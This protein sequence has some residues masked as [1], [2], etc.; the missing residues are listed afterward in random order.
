MG[1]KFDFLSVP[2]SKDGGKT[3][4]LYPKLVFDETISWKRIVE[5]VAHDTGFTPGNIVGVMHEVEARVLRYLSYGSRVQVGDMCYA[6]PTVETDRDIADESEVHAQ[7]V[8]FGKV[9]LHPAKNFRPQG[10]LV[11]ADRYSKF[12]KSSSDLSVQQRY[13]R[14]EAYLSEHGVI[15][16]TQYGELTGLLRTRAQNDL[17]RWLAEG[18]LESLGQ[19]THKVYRLSDK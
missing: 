5:E 1:A 10:P 14:L 19:A 8:R 16:R 13:E 4:I 17:N 11:R 2:N 6:E 3:R 18:K 12:R 7:S 9:K 15:S